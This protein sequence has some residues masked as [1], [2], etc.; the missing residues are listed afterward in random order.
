TSYTL[1]RLFVRP[2]R[3]ARRAEF[4]EFQPFCC[5][6]LVLGL[7]IVLPLALGALESNNFSR[8]RLLQ[9]LRYSPRAY[10]APAF[11]DRKP[12][13]LVHGHWRDQLYFQAHVVARHHHLHSLRQLRHARD[14][15][16]PEVKLRPVALEEWR[17]SPALILAQYVDF[18]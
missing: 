7:T 2:V 15:R 9:N 10:G 16:C 1:F 6:L 3:P 4:A 12:Q 18:A 17:V 8:H 5:R 13:A 14:V 11:A